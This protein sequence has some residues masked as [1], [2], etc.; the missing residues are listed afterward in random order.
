M[1]SKDDPDSKNPIDEFKKLEYW[2]KRQIL[3][4]RP[5]NLSEHVHAAY[6][7]SPYSDV[8]CHATDPE[9]LNPEDCMAFEKLMKKIMV[10]VGI[11]DAEER[12]GQ[13]QRLFTHF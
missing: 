9:N 1:E 2:V 11:V 4:Y 13:R 6:L 5:R 7:C 12:G 8:I 3:H 10:P